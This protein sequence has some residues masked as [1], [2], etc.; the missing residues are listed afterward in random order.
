MTTWIPTYLQ[1]M[2]AYIQNP[3]V[4]MYGRWNNP[5]SALEGGVDL[6]SP[7]GTQ[8]FALGSGTIVGLGYFCHPGGNI[9]NGSFQNATSD[10]SNG[11]P[12]YGVVTTR[13]DIPGY[14]MNDLYYQHIML[15]PNLKIGDTVQRGQLLGTVVPGVNEIEM[16]LNANWGTI[17]GNSH[18][19]AWATD[20]RPQIEALMQFGD[21]PQTGTSNPIDFGN[22]FKQLGLPNTADIQTFFQRFMIVWFGLTIILIGLLVMFFSSEAGHQTVQKGE[23]AAEMAAM[24]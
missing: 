6:T 22:F 13:V 5:A 2:L 1:D 17:W 20:P 19:A 23:Q 3:N 12:G 7:G 21:T 8:V 24:A 15:N 4:Y 11:K 9:P 16:G 18:P 10:C 14:G